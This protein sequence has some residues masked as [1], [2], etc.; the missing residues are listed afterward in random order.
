MK[1]ALVNK[2]KAFAAEFRA[3]AERM[4]RLCEKGEMLNLNCQFKVNPKPDNPK[5]YT[6]EC[7][8]GVKP[9]QL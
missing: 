4:A 6:S 3:A 1:D 7:V 9:E 2:R 5:K 8:I